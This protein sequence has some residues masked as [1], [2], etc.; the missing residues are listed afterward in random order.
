[1]QIVK[2][3]PDYMSSGLWDDGKNMDES[4]FDGILSISDLLA[5]K[6]WHHI[7]EMFA[8]DEFNPSGINMSEKFWNDWSRDG[9]DMVAEWNSKQ[10]D[11]QFVYKGDYWKDRE[12]K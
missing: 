2:V 8:L 10:K 7:W 9:R 4:E 11:I 1:M 12:V 5:L 3:L 6:Y